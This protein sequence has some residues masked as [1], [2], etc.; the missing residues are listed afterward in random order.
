M[1]PD[2]CYIFTSGKI[3]FD[4]T[5]KAIKKLTSSADI[6]ILSDSLNV[7]QN[8]D[9]WTKI[10]DKTAVSILK[11]LLNSFFNG[12]NSNFNGSRLTLDYDKEIDDILAKKVPLKYQ[13]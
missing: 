10:G 7:I 6:W 5:L 12:T 11:T 3:A 8:L 13:Y 1:N 9:N 2:F 4:V